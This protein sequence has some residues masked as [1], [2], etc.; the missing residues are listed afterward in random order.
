MRLEA[1]ELLE[2][3]IGEKLFDIGFIMI[4]FWMSHQKHKQ[5]KQK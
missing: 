4:F 2:K 3:D 1:T 5:E